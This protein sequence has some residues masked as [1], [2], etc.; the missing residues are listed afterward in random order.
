MLL[1]GVAFALAIEA[2]RRSTGGGRGHYVVASVVFAALTLLPVVG[3]TARGAESLN[4]L[5]TFLGA[6]YVIGGVLDHLELRRLL[7]GIPDRE[8]APTDG[9]PSAAGSR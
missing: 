5:F 9:A 3:L 1:S 2:Y 6:T 7:P 8:I 4:V